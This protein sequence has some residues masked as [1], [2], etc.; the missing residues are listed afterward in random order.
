[1]PQQ[2]TRDQAI[3]QIAEQLD[4]PIPLK[5]FTT[6]VL[7]IWPSRAKKPHAGV[8]QAMRDRHL[9]DTL[10][11][12]DKETVVPTRIGLSGV[13]LRVPLSRE[14]VNKGLM[15]IY[16]AFQFLLPRDLEVEK[17]QLVDASNN[18]IPTEI[19][20]RQVK[21]R[22]LL[23]EYVE[24][25][26]ALNLGWWYKKHKV[27]RQDNLL[28]TVLDWPAG[29]FRVQPESDRDYRR[30]RTEIEESNQQ[31]ADLLFELL[32]ASRY[33]RLQ[34][35]RAIPTVY[36]RLKDKWVHPADHWIQVVANDPRMR[37]DGFEIRYA[38][39]PTF[40]ERLVPELRQERASTAPVELSDSQRNEVYRFKAYFSFR[41]GLWR[42]IEIQGGQT[43]ADFDEMM[44]DAFE[45]D[46]MD[47]MG[48]FWQRIRRGKSR[49]FR[50]VKLATINPF[51]EGEGAEKQIASLNLEPGDK[52]KYVYDFGD[53]IEH[54]IDLEALADPEAEASYPRVV[55]QNKPRYKYC[56]SCREEGRKTVATYICLQC[57]NREQRE[58]IMC[59]DCISPDHDDHYLQEILY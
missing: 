3:T 18:R 32:E 51:R 53:W 10:L 39:S 37:W 41:K 5:E 1:M 44:R 11:F 19:I 20:T 21:K 38:E 57:S 30:N 47:H 34:G 31:L 9:G 17:L 49:R 52:L 54:Y 35:R 16:P 55:A 58:V 7:S 4:E 43:L 23:G 45:H 29:K 46:M 15:Y 27:R 8:R 22:S 13:C 2:L 14:E 24:D 48:G 59:E 56:P 33:E 12:L 6:R 36:A 42:R 28:L 25:I 26:Y 40:M 50:E